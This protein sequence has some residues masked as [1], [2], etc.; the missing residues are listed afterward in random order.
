VTPAGPVLPDAQRRTLLKQAL[1]AVENLKARIR[2]LE[3]GATGPIAIVGAGCRLPGGIRNLDDYWQLLKDGRDAVT[4]LT[5]ERWGVDGDTGWHAGLVEGI[6]QFDPKFFNISAR[7]A[8]TMDPQQRMVVE[9]AWEAIENA[10]IPP[11]SLNGSRT[12]VFIGITAHEYGTMVAD[13]CGLDLDVYTATGNAHNVSAGRISYLLGLQGPSMA[14][15]TAC[16][17]SLVSIHLACQSLRTGE[18]RIALAGGTSA[19]LAQD[20]FLCFSNWKM[21]A[22]DGRCKTFDAR[23]DG[24]VRAEGCGIVVLKRLAD[25]LADGDHIL[26]LIRGSAVNQ[27]GKS[28]G[29]T[30]PNGNAQ[31]AVIRQALANGGIEPAAVGYAEAHGTGTSLGDPIEAHALGSALGVGRAADNP[32]VVGSVKT[33]LGHLES[34]AGV[35]GLLKVVLALDKE[36]IPA[37][38]H[39]HSMNPQL[40]WGGAPVEIASKARPWLRG[41]K[42]RFGGVSAFGFSGTNAHVVLEEAPARETSWSEPG[43]PL[44]LLALSARS[45]MALRELATRYAGQLTGIDASTADICHTANTGRTHFEYRL[46]VTGGSREELKEQLAVAHPG[47][48]VREREAA[49]P[50]FL[51]PG[52]GA[53]YPGMGKQLY[54]TQPL[55]RNVID[56]CTEAL[57]TELEQPL[58]SVLW[59]SDPQLLLQTAYTQPALFAVEYALAQ[60]WRRWGIEPAAI[61]GHSVGEYV[62]ACVAGVYSLA[63][64]L[65][66]IA[67]RARMM[68]AVKGEGIMLAAT[69]SESKARL[70]IAGLEER[71]S[72]AAVNG[73][74]NIVLSG[75]RRELS[76][77]EE[78]L[79]RAGA[80][81]VRLAVSHAFH[82]PQMREIEDAFETVAAGVKF[83]RPRIKLISSVTGRAIEQDQM[84]DPGYWRRQVREPVRFQSAIESLQQQATFLEVGP[85]TTLLGLGS[86]C[87]GSEDR[88]WLPSVRNGHEDW[89]QLLQSLGS[90][91]VSGAE[92]NWDEFDESLHGRRVVL[93][94]YPFERQR[95]WVESPSGAKPGRSRAADVPQD[96][97]AAPAVDDWFH[98][99]A[100]HEIPRP[101]VSAEKADG[102]WIVLPDTGGVGDA[103][104]AIVRATGSSCFVAPSDDE[105]GRIAASR[106]GKFQVV[107]LRALQ[108]VEGAAVELCQELAGL[109][110][111]LSQRDSLA[112]RLWVV[113]AGAQGLDG[114]VVPWQAPVWGLGRTISVEHA[115]L[116]G[117]LVDL[118]PAAEASRNAA[119]LWQHILSG[120]GEDQVAFRNGRR[121]AARLER[122]VA[123][124]I[125][126]PVFGP[127]GAYLIT[128]G[129][130]ALGLDVA[131]WLVK[132]GARRLILMGRTLPPPRREWRSL[133]AGSPH[134]PAVKAIQAMESGGASVHMA[135]VDVGDPV[136]LSR[137]FQSYEEECLPPIR[138]LVHAAGV[139][140]HT[141]LAEV[142]AEKF[143]ELFHAKVDGAWRLHQAL[144]DKSLDF[145]LLF[146]SASSLVSLPQMGPYA[147]ANAFLDGLAAYRK[148]LGLCA[149]SV[150][151]GPWIESGM[152]ARF[153]AEGGG[154]TAV[155]ETAGMKTE[156]GLHCLLR[157]FGEETAGIAVLPGNWRAWAQA[158]S[159]LMASRFLAGLLGG[160]KPAAAES[161]P[162]ALREKLL[163][164]PVPERNARLVTY[165]RDA[166]AAI[167]GFDASAVNP[168]R[169]ITECGVDSLMVLELR[170]RMTSDLGVTISNKRLLEG[171]TLVELAHY[172]ADE[173]SKST[174][175]AAAPAEAVADGGYPLSYGQQAQWFRHKIAPDS[176]TF[177]IGF[178]AKVSPPLNWA[179]FERAVTKLVARHSAFRTVFF[180]TADGKP[181]QRV[182]A[183]AAPEISLS[184]ATAWPEAELEQNVLE[185]FGK[186]FELD[187]PLFRISVF[188][189]A[190][191]DILLFNVHHMIMD[192]WSLRISFRDLKLLYNAELEGVE[193]ALEPLVAD[194]REFV[195][196]EASM[197]EGPECERLWEYWKRQLGGE[198]PLLRLPSSRGRPAVLAA[199]GDWIPLILSDSVAQGVR[200]VARNSKTTPYTVVLAAFQILLHCYTGQDD[201]IVGT[202]TSGRDNPRWANLVGYF[203]NLLAI[204]AS[205]PG[206]LSFAK[207]L[208]RCRE[209]V[210]DAIEHQAL[211]FPV[212]V[213][214]LRLQRTLERTPVFQAFFNYL[215]DPAGELSSLFAPISDNS[216]PFGASS[217]RPYFAIPQQLGQSEVVLQMFEVD[218]RF[219]AHLNYNIDIL[220]RATAESMAA[221]YSRILE[222]ITI[223]PNISIGELSLE[224]R[225]A[226]SGID[227]FVF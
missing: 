35:A 135:A 162:A 106:A 107:D 47:P 215:T 2:S 78:N 159:G 61:L 90:L 43:R 147:A 7:E 140:R 172:L 17:S 224:A 60:L 9:V 72:I 45:E 113:T 202:S 138:G 41:E 105:F 191:G 169:P 137:F 117:G 76:Q 44:H 92:V 226:E 203:V 39:F 84:S 58:T 195:E 188:R 180:D 205:L 131:Q 145:F 82:S 194:F 29:L 199:R 15:D 201:I 148:S 102:D 12:G 74:E 33:N 171:P 59:G 81:V 13:R 161:E 142:S 153:A 100:W 50:V 208:V 1:D 28:S 112:A 155:R 166:L 170:N 193:P 164:A 216:V 20:P 94:T 190:D 213:T 149:M 93:P 77:V 108:A 125:K 111:D 63:D 157:L 200:L 222:A 152:Y 37:Q 141:P 225:A 128:G 65:K 16:S 22:A 179:A 87:L 114:R 5:G 67:A 217:L 51:F 174:G 132:H 218:G 96:P 110:R 119:M 89:A 98:A 24:L 52:Q 160:K 42:K 206:D 53:Q 70:A 3:S 79:V 168:L 8:R 73:P 91:Y 163:Q 187:R 143:R 220:D 158:H 178:T 214:R 136:A 66:L 173:L 144:K 129:F 26:A 116:W 198:L 150:N 23:A 184:D 196:W 181:I 154:K 69:I 56:E 97:G 221:D 210:L 123:P 121:M 223:N 36:E 30:V 189:R 62:G 32:L 14:I 183:S 185:D 192:A 212:L 48:R 27:D 207:H 83:S 204:R 18:C 40:D 19:I 11:K 139:V 176:A 211:P 85:G 46:A 146:S 10:G 219:A 6:D 156:E 64:G 38:L 101:E 25:A 95:Y 75:Y 126:D 54:E 177:N 34:A 165:L 109:V 122:Q 103:L 209:T 134:V 99:V 68:Q 130:G 133:P 31:E 175:P 151:W 227:E 167:V 21:L 55:F 197:S 71:V 104:V 115:E 182:M 127:G 86:Q 49:R 57:K 4:R 120:D 118:D 88:L 186:P 80:R 124:A